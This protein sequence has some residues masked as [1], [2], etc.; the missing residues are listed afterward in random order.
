MY[1]TLCGEREAVHN[2]KTR[3]KKRLGLKIS[4][5]AEVLIILVIA[6]KFISEGYEQFGN[7]F[8]EKNTYGEDVKISDAT[9]LELEEVSVKNIKNTELLWLINSKHSIKEQISE[10]AMVSAFHRIALSRSDIKFNKSTLENIED[11]FSRAKE[12]GIDD[13]VVTSGFRTHQKQSSLYDE[14]KDKSYVALPGC[15][16]HETGLA[17]DIQLTR[18]GMK[19]LG[20]TTE[21][22]WLEKNAWAFGFILRYPEDKVKITGIS[23]ESW[24]FRYVGLPHAAFMQKNGLCLEE[25]IDYLKNNKQYSIKIGNTSYQVYR[26]VAKSGKIEVPKNLKYTVSDDNCGGYI[27]SVILK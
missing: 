25:Y 4:I 3:K 17:A 24:H 7:N 27:V 10:S 11:M 15:S 9:D 26:T 19:E 1:I 22:Q 14:A 21:G 23:Y 2:L 20:E 5:V 6:G 12:D 18:G 16:E 13:L 8:N